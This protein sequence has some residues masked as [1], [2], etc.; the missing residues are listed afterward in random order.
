M[1]RTMIAKRIGVG[2][3]SFTGLTFLKTRDEI[4]KSVQ[5]L[6]ADL[7]TSLGEVDPRVVE[8]CKKW[9]LTFKEVLE[10]E[11]ERHHRS[12]KKKQ[13]PII[14]ALEGD[15]ISSEVGSTQ[16]ITKAQTGL[17]D[18]TK[19]MELDRDVSMVTRY[20]QQIFEV[21]D[22]MGDLKVIVDNLKATPAATR[23]MLPD[24]NLQ[25]LELTYDELIELGF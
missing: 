14:M 16:Y 2:R 19:L 1:E 11:R 3:G 22:R 8:L 6:Y 9:D 21:E 13:V 18:R 7:E 4:L 15:E 24:P 10:E 25:P 17:R 12:L 20:I 23:N 5:E